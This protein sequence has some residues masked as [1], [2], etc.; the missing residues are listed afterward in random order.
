MV[1]LCWCE[2]K[3]I[4]FSKVYSLQFSLITPGIRVLNYLLQRTLHSHFNKNHAIR[5]TGSAH[6]PC[7]DSFHSQGFRPLFPSNCCLHSPLCTPC[8]AHPHMQAL[9]SLSFPLMILP[10]RRYP[11]SL[12]RVRSQYSCSG[13]EAKLLHTRT[14]QS[15]HWS[16]SHH[17]SYLLFF[18]FIYSFLF[19]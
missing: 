6:V 19:T 18:S 7:Y 16:D 4:A 11:I 5:Q 8:D 13:C 2:T 9:P 17:P 12:S 10:T 1:V 3:R 15:C 14:S